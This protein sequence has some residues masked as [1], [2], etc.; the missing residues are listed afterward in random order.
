M[1]HISGSNNFCACS[2][3]NTAAQMVLVTIVINPYPL[4]V[5]FRIEEKVLRLS[6]TFNIRLDLCYIISVRINM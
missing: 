3:R 6:K 2:I 5:I 1:F 4:Y